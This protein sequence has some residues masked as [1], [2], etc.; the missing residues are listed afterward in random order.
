[1]ITAYIQKEGCLKGRPVER[2]DELPQVAV[3]IDLLNPTPEE[4]ELVER[5]LR[6]DLPTLEEMREIETSSRLYQDN[7]AFFMTAILIHRADTEIPDSV[8]VTF[9]LAGHRLITLRHAEP[10]PFRLFAAQTAK[11]GTAYHNGELALIGLLDAIVDRL[12]DILERIQE[13]VAALSRDVFAHDKRRP[14]EGFETVLKKLGRDQGLVGRARE[15]LVSISRLLSFLGRSGDHPAA[16][17]EVERGVRTLVQDVASLSDHT[18]YISN[19]I[20]FLLEAILG[21]ISIE[22]N[23]IIKI[24]SVA[25]VMFLPPTLIASVYGMNFEVMPELAWPY[26]Y[27]VVLL[28]MLLSAVTPYLYFKRRGWL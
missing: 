6:L 14:R 20:N 9:I 5:G 16:A 21:L 11:P 13:S 8:P 18:S 25:A 1:M 2:D 22:Q 27:P 7:G 4:V 19:N 24:F 3:W 26:A 15:S 17:R 28:L 23:N 10:Q 12:A